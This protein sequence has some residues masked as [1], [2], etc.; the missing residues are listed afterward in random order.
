MGLRR[1][2]FCW[3]AAC[4]MALC[5]WPAFAQSAADV[6]TFGNPLLPSGPD[7]WV[8]ADGGYYYFM[9]T[10]GQNLTVRRTRDLA[11][12]ADAE[13]KVVWT[14]P[15]TG[16]YSE[17]IWA[18]ELHKIDGK[19]YIYF[20]AD[21]GNNANHRIYAIENASANPLNGEWTFKGRVSDATDKWAID[22]T[23]FKARGQ[24]Y[25]L[26]S[27][28]AGDTDGE[29][30]IYIAHMR[31]PWTIDSPRTELS[32][33]IYSWELGGGT[34]AAPIPHQVRVNEGP[35]ILQHKGRIF[36][37]YSASPCWTDDYELGMLQARARSKLLQARSWTKLDHPVF[38]QDAAT[39]VYGPGH[40]GFF[41]S[42]DGRQSWIIY[43]ANSAPGQGCGGSRSPRM[44]P[45]TWKPD[46]MPDF[47]KPVSTSTEL[48][49]PGSF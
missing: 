11:K 24:E 8:I 23:V 46:G 28:W 22:A 42:P 17:Q 45:F 49:G 48:K 6:T 16:P 12:L 2:L 31:N 34:L 32:R 44:Q 36:L 33:P 19:W 40:N 10:T 29:Q 37:V 25:M 39:G 35:E 26:W 3:I 7:P 27:G 5:I 13:V 20:A 18:P 1:F 21:D 47:G 14:P 30:R 4:A 43:H 41:E 38:R 15:V 9:A